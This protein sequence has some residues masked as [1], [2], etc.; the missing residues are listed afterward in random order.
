MRTRGGFTLLEMLL[1]T[2][3]AA[4]LL[5]LLLFVAMGVRRTERIMAATYAEA[6][7]HEEVFRV[8][9]FDLVHARVIESGDNRLSIDGYGGLDAA[10]LEATGLPCSVSYGVQDVA[11][12]PT[13]VRRQS[14]VGAGDSFDELVAVGAEGFEVRVERP[15]PTGSGE[16][17]LE[18]VEE[19]PLGLPIS[20]TVTVRFGDAEYRRYIPLK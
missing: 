4:L 13:L 14:S 8:I 5:M 7:R 19:D 18:G 3:L 17:G 15:E 2:A 11:G 12:Q 10:T 6:E 20:A 1:A 16:L 9:A